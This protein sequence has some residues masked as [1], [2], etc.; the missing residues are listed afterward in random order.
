MSP[1]PPSSSHPSTSTS[2]RRSTRSTSPTPC[3]YRVSIVSRSRVIPENC[4]TCIKSASAD[5]SEENG[6]VPPERKVYSYMNMRAKVG[7]ASL[8]ATGHAPCGS[9]MTAIPVGQPGSA[10]QRE[11]IRILSVH[12]WLMNRSDTTSASRRR[13]NRRW[14]V[15]ACN[16]V[17][18][19]RGTCGTHWQ[20]VLHA[21]KTPKSR[22]PSAPNLQTPTPKSPHT[23]GYW[24]GSAMS[25]ANA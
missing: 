14:P 3:E 7:S 9:L 13:L 25:E 10:L 6:G 20:R 21:R 1:C 23:P 8:A 18:D 4:C 24:S 17:E 12:H 22:P 11:W 16:F 15:S 19:G 5:G 2:S